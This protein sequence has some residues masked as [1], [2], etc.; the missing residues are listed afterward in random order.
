MSLEWPH[1]QT[2]ATVFALL[3]YCTLQQIGS[4]YTVVQSLPLQVTKDSLR[5]SLPTKI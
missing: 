2:L 4:F 1:D 5:S 3:A